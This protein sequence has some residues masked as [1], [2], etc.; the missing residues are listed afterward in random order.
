MRYVDFRDAIRDELRRNPKGLTWPQLREGLDLPYHSP[1]S[2]W[3]KQ[4]EQELISLRNLPI[5]ENQDNETS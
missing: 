1:C 3:I 2:T 4:M 5:T